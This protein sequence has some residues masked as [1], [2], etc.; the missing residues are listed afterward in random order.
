LASKVWDLRKVHP[1]R[2]LQNE[3]GAKRNHGLNEK[4]SNQGY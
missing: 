2:N 1:Y 3:K 4:K